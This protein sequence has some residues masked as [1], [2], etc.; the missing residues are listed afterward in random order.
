ML[1]RTLLSSKE[2]ARTHTHARMNAGLDAAELRHQ[3]KITMRD[4]E[5]EN[6]ARLDAA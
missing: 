2:R 1:V 3:L 6:I 4:R 5:R